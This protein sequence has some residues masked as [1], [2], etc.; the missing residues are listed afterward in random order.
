MTG[1]EF[2]VGVGLL[3]MSEGQFAV[4]LDTHKFFGYC[5]T[6]WRGSLLPLGR[7]AAPKKSD[8]RCALKREQAP[9]PQKLPS[10]RATD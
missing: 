7:A 5:T 9:S 6:L 1:A 2:V 3:A 4:M 10:H 8:E